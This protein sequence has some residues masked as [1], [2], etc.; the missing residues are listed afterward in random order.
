MIAFRR[1]P[2]THHPWTLTPLA[3]S[4]NTSSNSRPKSEGV[5]TDSARGRN[6]SCCWRRKSRVRYRPNS[7]RIRAGGTRST[8]TITSAIAAPNDHGHVLEAGV[9]LPDQQLVLLE[10]P[11]LRLGVD[12]AL[13]VDLVAVGQRRDHPV[14]EGQRGVDEREDAAGRARVA[15]RPGGGGERDVGIAG[16]A[17][18]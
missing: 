13:R 3:H 18:H 2:A 10:R 11:A 8:A 16:H 5:R 6:T 7:P 14:A 15:E 17:L 1:G 9:A 4:R 12:P